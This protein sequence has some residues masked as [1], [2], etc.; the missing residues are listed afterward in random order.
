MSFVVVISTHILAISKGDQCLCLA[1]YWISPFGDRSVA[2]PF[3]FDTLAIRTICF[4]ASG[5][6]QTKEAEEVDMKERGVWGG[7]VGRLAMTCYGMAIA[8]YMCICP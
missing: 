7:L 5:V 4:S 6:I 3:G 8:V 1:R 2:W